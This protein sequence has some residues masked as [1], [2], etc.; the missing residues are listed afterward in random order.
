MLCYTTSLQIP[1]TL[2]GHLV[3]PL[4]IHNRQVPVW[5]RQEYSGKILFTE[6]DDG[7]MNF[8]CIGI[9]MKQIYR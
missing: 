4:L 8:D 2:S 6:T 7:S 1:S 5:V 3:T 9:V